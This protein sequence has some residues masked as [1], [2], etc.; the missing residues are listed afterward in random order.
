MSLTMVENPGML[1]FD[2]VLLSLLSLV[3]LTS[4]AVD[5]GALLAVK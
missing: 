5:G 2:V 1:C 4:V 3:R